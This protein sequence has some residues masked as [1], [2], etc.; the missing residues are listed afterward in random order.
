M[1]WNRTVPLLSGAFLA[2]CTVLALVLVPGAGGQ[3]DGFVLDRPPQA[4]FVTSGAPEEYHDLPPYEVTV[5]TSGDVSDEDVR[6]VFDMTPLKGDRI[7]ALPP[8]CSHQNWVI[9]CTLPPGTGNAREVRSLV[10][11]HVASSGEASKGV[12]PGERVQIKAEFSAPGAETLRSSTT[13]VFAS[14]VGEV[15]LREPAGEIAPGTEAPL[16]LSFGNE[17]TGGSFDYPQGV[18]LHLKAEPVDPG[19]PRPALTFPARHSNC[20]YNTTEAPTEI[21]CDFPGPMPPDTGYE[22]VS[23]VAVAV[24]PGSRGGRIVADIIPTGHEF[25]P[26]PLPADAPRGTGDPLKVKPAEA[27]AASRGRWAKSVLMTTPLAQEGFD[28][29]PSP[30]TITGEVG[31]MV[32]LVIPLSYGSGDTPAL[33]SERPGQVIADWP[34]NLTIP[35]GFSYVPYRPEDGQTDSSYCPRPVGR[36]SSCPGSAEVYGTIVRLRIDKKV[37]GATSRLELTDVPEGDRV[38]ANNSRPVEVVVHG[39][40]TPQPPPGLLARPVSWA[41][42]GAALLGVAG[43][44][45]RRSRRRTDPAV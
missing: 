42:G 15:S 33:P 14:F 16:G 29:A 25:A 26:S 4:L 28:L 41:I 31:E 8:N 3:P 7:G 11:F 39:Q 9:T 34:Q 1:R 27:P 19:E 22:L 43:L 17:H 32:E 44:L 12:D 24:A 23:P 37:E 5:R 40:V 10:P 20:R 21:L 18:T 36:V 35:E 2:L 45:W 38:A 6:A 13:V 30:L